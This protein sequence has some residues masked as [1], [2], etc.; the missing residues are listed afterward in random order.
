[1]FQFSKLSDGD[2]AIVQRYGVTMPTAIQMKHNHLASS[3]TVISFWEIFH[4]VCFTVNIFFQVV[5]RSF[6]KFYLALILR[7]LC[8]RKT[9]HDVAKWFG[10]SRGNVQKLGTRTISHIRCLIRFCD[11]FPELTPMKNV[12]KDFVGKLAH[13]LILGQTPCNLNFKEMLSQMVT[14][15]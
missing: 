12:L 2:M 11:T 10:I 1:M 7:E 6:H 14:V 13:N 9:P 8:L 15:L 4:H 3:L 5:R